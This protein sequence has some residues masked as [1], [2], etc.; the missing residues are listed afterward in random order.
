MSYYVITSTV[1]LGGENEKYQISDL[2]LFFILFFFFFHRWWFNSYIQDLFTYPRV[3]KIFLQKFYK[4]VYS[5]V[6]DPN[7]IFEQ[8]QSSFFSHVDISSYSTNFLI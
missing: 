1:N 3:A 4:F 7:L 8:V 5:Q 6:C 2:M